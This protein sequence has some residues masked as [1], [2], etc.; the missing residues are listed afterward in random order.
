MRTLSGHLLG[1]PLPHQFP[2]SL[3]W[4][5]DENSQMLI[6]NVGTNQ[7]SI[8]AIVGWCERGVR[9]LLPHFFASWDCL[10]PW[11]GRRIVPLPDPCPLKRF[12]SLPLGYLAYTFR[13]VPH[14]PI[15]VIQKHVSLLSF[16]KTCDSSNI[17]RDYF[18]HCNIISTP[19]QNIS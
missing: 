15:V 1:F 19:H 6:Q 9:L 5:S 2:V 16:V 12:R 3:T 7:A 4:P 10:D 18:F 13:Y 8:L 14:C 17:S 11:G